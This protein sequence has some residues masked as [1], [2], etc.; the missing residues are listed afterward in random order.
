MLNQLLINGI[1][2]G[3]VYTL[4]ALGFTI[5]YRTVKFFHFADA[6]VYAI[7]VFAPIQW[8]IQHV[9]EIRTTSYG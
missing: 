9:N 5:I 3:S 4:T 1:I 6:V 2:T 8:I 7:G